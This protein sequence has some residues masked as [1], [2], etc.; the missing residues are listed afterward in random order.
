MAVLIIIP[1]VLSWA[2]VLV[3]WVRSLRAHLHPAASPRR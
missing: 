3:L 1:A 2:A